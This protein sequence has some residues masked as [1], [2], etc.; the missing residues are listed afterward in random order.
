MLLVPSY[1]KKIV[2]VF[3][4]F[5]KK[6]KKEKKIVVEF[7]LKRKTRWCINSHEIKLTHREINKVFFYNKNHFFADDISV[8]NHLQMNTLNKSYSNCSIQS[9]TSSSSYQLQILSRKNSIENLN[10][11]LNETTTNLNNQNNVNNSCKRKRR[12]RRN[13]R[14][15]KKKVDKK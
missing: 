6:V 8:K 14:G 15:N 2:F 3:L 9:Q 7:S 12:K 10:F 1:I 13:K 5:I 4:C 11:I